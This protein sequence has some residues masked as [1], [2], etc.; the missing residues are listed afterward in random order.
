VAD[1]DTNKK[2]RVRR[3][4]DMEGIFGTETVYFC[5]RLEAGGVELLSFV[6]SQSFYTRIGN[7]YFAFLP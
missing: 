2:D 3:E 4:V 6:R 7:K 5:V 1:T